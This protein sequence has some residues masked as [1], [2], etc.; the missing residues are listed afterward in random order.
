M[1]AD[2]LV[3]T[4]DLSEC[5]GWAWT[6]W[7]AELPLHPDGQP[8]GGE[9]EIWCKATDDAYNSQPDEPAN[10]WNLRGVLNNAVHRVTVQLDC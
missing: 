9:V 7:N 8:E 6:L 5:R 10:I 4:F 2:H 1:T 3:R